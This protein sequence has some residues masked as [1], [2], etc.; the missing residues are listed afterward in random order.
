MLAAV[1]ATRDYSFWLGM[2]VLILAVIAAFVKM[3]REPVK[4][5]LVVTARVRRLMTALLIFLWAGCLLSYLLGG[6][7]GDLLGGTVYGAFAAP[8]LVSL[9]VLLLPYMVAL[10]AWF[11]QPFE[12]MVKRKFFHRRKDGLPLLKT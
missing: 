10:P 7:A 1:P 11:M 2:A 4:K 12:K 3:K 8:V 5:D 9:W 6:A